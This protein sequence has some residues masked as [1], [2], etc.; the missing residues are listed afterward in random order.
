MVAQ[1]NNTR[2][3]MSSPAGGFSDWACPP[4]SAAEEVK[5]QWLTEQVR[6]SRTYLEGQPA[7]PDIERARMVLAGDRPVLPEGRSAIHINRIKRQIREIVATITDFRLVGEF[8]TNNR[9]FFDNL[10]VLRKLYLG[11]YHRRNVRKSLRSVFQYTAV[12]GTG[13]ASPRAALDMGSIAGEIEIELDAYGALGVLPHQNGTDNNIQTCY[14]VSLY[15][16]IPLHRAHAVYPEFRG[17]LSPSRANPRYAWSPMRTFQRYGSLVLGMFGLGSAR[18]AQSA[19]PVVDV[20]QTYVQDLST[21]TTGKTI[22][23]G[24]PGTSWYYEVPS[25]G[26]EIATGE[27][28]ASGR[29]TYRKATT[30][31]ALLYPLRRLIIWTD[32]CVIYDGTSKWWH[33]MV[34]AVQFRMDDWA[35]DWLGYS[36][37]HDNRPIQEAINSL[38][39]VMVD[40]ANLKLNPPLGYSPNIGKGEATKVDLRQPGSRLMLDESTGEYAKPLLPPQYYTIDQQTYQMVFETLPQVMDH[41]MGVQDLMALAKAKKQAPGGDTL[42]QLLEAAGPLV[43][44]IASNIESSVEQLVYMVM[45]LMFQFYTTPRKIMLVGTDQITPEEYDFQ[46]NSMV[47]S[48]LPG[49]DTSRASMAGLLERAKRHMKQF[50]F[51]V[52]PGSLLNITGMQRQLM[53]AQLMKLGLPVSWWTMFEAMS[54]P[55]APEPEGAKNELERWMA[56]KRLEAAMAAELQG[57]VQG[58]IGAAG[59]GQPGRP[60]SF[61]EAP[62]LEQRPDGSSTVRTSEGGG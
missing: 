61:Q 31:D 36:L 42:Q 43:K 13:Y 51:W 19:F 58:A 47:P 21:N 32:T 18:E 17:R 7:Y 41:Q 52:E 11:W 28:D 1:L 37:V 34:P 6:L 14:A 48:H 10:G 3:Q 33:G 29:D 60:Q 26:S 20:Y 5:L 46:P 8:K 56:Q 25:L 16:E 53:L 15:N 24:E 44:D 62:H 57:A 9:D 39:R 38:L 49:E 59:G 22:A 40:N 12:E 45:C 23:M 30:T 50:W 35:W 55:F 54:M 2:G 4:E 27:K